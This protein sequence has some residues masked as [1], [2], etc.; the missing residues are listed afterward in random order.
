MRE[1]D[2]QD[3]TQAV[4]QLCLQAACN[5]PDDVLHALDAAAEA[6]ESPLGC[7]ALDK[8]V[9]NARI[10]AQRQVPLC[11]DTGV[12]LVF[13]EV[14]QDVHVVGGSFEQAVNEGVAM[15]YTQG[16]LRKSMVA[17][18]LFGRVNTAD[19]TPAIIHTRLVPGDSLAITL[20]PKGAGSE[21]MT[22][23]GM[24]KPADGVEGVRNFV[25][26]VVTQ[27][28]GNPCP[29]TIVGV[30]VGGNAEG[31]VLLS[32]QALRR[33]VGQHHARPEYA[34][35]EDEL[36]AAINDSGIGPQG[37]G[38]RV[39]ALAVHIEAAPTHIAMLPVAVT[40]NCHAARHAQVEL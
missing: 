19:N 37:F 32:K 4:A 40:L 7:W 5:L 13:A 17:D 2:A 10:A 22:K 23:L 9:R 1:I 14:G 20:M 8:V 3:I 15:G 29:P 25:V 31:A 16:Y 38:G 30:G 11:Q 27:A 21:N 39:T 35:L 26:D 33:P 36:L 12:A 6:E 24:L 18:P 34:Q 28:G